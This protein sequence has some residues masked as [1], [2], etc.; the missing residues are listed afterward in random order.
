M[1]RSVLLSLGLAWAAVAPAQAGTFDRA[2]IAPDLG[3]DAF[4]R[5]VAR[6]QLGRDVF[7]NPYA[8][9]TIGTVDVYDAFPYVE[10]RNFQVVS[11]PRWN[12]LICGEA[13]RALSAY[14]GIGRPLGALSNPRGMAV[15]ERQRL[16]VADTGN[17]RVLVLEARTEYS[18]IDLVPVFEI[19][20]LSRPYDVSYSDGG[21]P[22][23]E[24]DD[25]LYVADTGK[26]RIVA[27]AL[28]ASGATRGAE[29]GR[30][31]S[32]AG[33]FAGPLA[34][35]TGRSDGANTRD[36]YVADA[37]TRRIVHLRHG[38]AGWQWVAEAV[39]AADVV[40]SLETDQWGNLYAAAP[41][42]GVVRKFNR[43]LEPVAELKNALTNPKS[44]HLPFVTLRDHRVG[45]VERVGRPAAVSVDGW[46]DATGVGLWN[47]GVEVHALTVQAGATPS[48]AFQL[49]DRASV[50]VELA[51]AATGRSL[52]RRSAGVLEAGAHTVALRDEDV[53]AASGAGDV[54]LRVSAA[55]SYPDGPQAAAQ[56]PYPGGG[57]GASTTRAMLLGN[58]P[59]PVESSTRI[60]FVLPAG[61]TEGVRLQ[62]FDASGR[63]MRAFDRGFTAGLNEVVWDGAD[64]HGRRASAGVYFYRLDAGRLAFTRKMILVR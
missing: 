7:S 19:R 26:N 63:L 31:G 21:T 14:D 52:S 58:T 42:Q 45:R 64:A 39:Q 57:A 22:F 41:H 37:H 54:M 47:L 18:R 6:E 32:G 53:R 50:T 40:T 2:P 24:G 61:A 62:V 29:I 43:A 16:Y 25:R 56:A 8:T 38:T 48:A 36:V 5:K 51:D 60:L 27:F 1:K 15:D 9:V 49:T 20:G 30:L 13:G 44:F 28:G 55:S 11:D 17:D 4:T 33:C 35:A 10:T 3:M 46:G 59:N 23:V 12:R 34:I